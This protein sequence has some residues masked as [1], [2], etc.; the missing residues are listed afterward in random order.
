MNL[1]LTQRALELMEEEKW[2]EAQNVLKEA[3]EKNPCCE[4]YNNM[5]V[6]YIDN[7]A[8]FENDAE[9]DAVKRG[10][11]YLKAA[12]D[13]DI[14]YKNLIALA[15]YNYYYGSSQ[16]ACE[17][18]KKVSEIKEDYRIYNNMGCCCY[19]LKGYV[20]ACIYFDKAL[21]TAD[22]NT[23]DIKIS[24]CYALNKC[25]EDYSE[26]L[27]SISN[28]SK[29]ELD[30]FILYFMANNMEKAY[31]LAEKVIEKWEFNTSVLAMLYECIEK[32]NVMALN[33][34]DKEVLGLINT[35][36]KRKKL[37]EEYEYVP[38]ML[39]QCK[40]IGCKKH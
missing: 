2:F 20:K 9:T 39:W 11:E 27:E 6:F 38:V 18:Y 4:S 26:I 1:E 17:F 14:E 25:K 21:K 3:V 32:N 22:K 31:L 23:D 36:A 13:C 5:G 15:E 37:I 7:G 12:Y 30:R 29:N 19:A 10:Y 16:K 28:D 35:S 8:Q 40:Y 24:Y 34:F 33:K